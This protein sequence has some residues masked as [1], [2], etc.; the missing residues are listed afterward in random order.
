MKKIFIF[1][2]IIVAITFPLYWYYFG[3]VSDSK[4]TIIFIIPKN[5]TGFDLVQKTGRRKIHQKK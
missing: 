5:Q 4:E 3:P 1:L 2:L